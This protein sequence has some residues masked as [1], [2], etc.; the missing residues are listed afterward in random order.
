MAVLHRQADID[1]TMH[2]AS[3]LDVVDIKLLDHIIVGSGKQYQMRQ[4]GLLTS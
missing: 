2:L 1:A 4:V 3:A